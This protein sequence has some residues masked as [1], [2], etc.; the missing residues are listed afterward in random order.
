M[1][2]KF[3]RELRE[4]LSSVSGELIFEYFL[5]KDVLK[6]LPSGFPSNG[7]LNLGGYQ[8][9]LCKSVWSMLQTSW[10]G[11]RDSFES[12][13]DYPRG[14]RAAELN[15]KFNELFPLMETVAG[16][17]IV[18]ADIANPKSRVIYFDHEGGDF[19]G[20]VLAPSFTQFMQTWC[21]L[22]CPSIDDLSLFYSSSQKRLA[23][24]TEPAIQWRKFLNL[25]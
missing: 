13:D 7:E 20:T 9:A 5:L 1:K 22:A 15:L 2:R 6:T 3:P 16:N 23:I 14:P 11:W 8:P 18:L 4:F 24:D 21:A 17:V 19:D 10:G 12:P 25:P